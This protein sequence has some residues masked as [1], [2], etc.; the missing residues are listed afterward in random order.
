VQ[1]GPTEPQSK[2]NTTQ[3]ESDQ[4]SA[5]LSQDDSLTGSQTKEPVAFDRLLDRLSGSDS[6]LP[7]VLLFAGVFLMVILLMRVLRKNTQ[8]NRRR[9]NNQGSPSRR[10]ADIHAQAQSSITPSTKAMVDAEEMARRLGA[11]LDNKAAR[12]ELLIEEADRKLN[13][14][15]RSIAGSKPTAFV[16]P[17]FDTNP[18]APTNVPASRTIDPTLLDRA[19]LEQDYHERQS[20]VAGRIEPAPAPA[21]PQQEEPLVDPTT[22]FKTRVLKLAD[23]GM[24]N[25]EIAHELKQPI[26]QVELIL[27]LRQQQG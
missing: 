22:Q 13:I 12:L 19:R 18:D 9:S 26:G 21:A 25:I 15:N 2:A 4:E 14:L 8:A 1:L 24:S 5:S 6:L 20:R 3:L 23:S 7:N 11:I 10:I 27:N 17:E 16:E